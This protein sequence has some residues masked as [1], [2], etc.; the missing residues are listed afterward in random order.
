MP[1]VSHLDP[2]HCDPASLSKPGAVLARHT[3]YP[4]ALNFVLTP[5]QCWGD[6]VDCHAN[7]APIFIPEW[8]YY[9]RMSVHC[10]AGPHGEHGPKHMIYT[11]HQDYNK[12]VYTELCLQH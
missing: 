9:H 10:S 12:A 2:G 8:P 4:A 11:S 7:S 6:S 5:Q 1:G 3:L